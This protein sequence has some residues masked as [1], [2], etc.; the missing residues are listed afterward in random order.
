MLVE[1]SET[2]RFTSHKSHT[3]LDQLTQA[4]YNAGE[5]IKIALIDCGAKQ[6]IIRCLASRGAEV[7]VFPWNYPIAKSAQKYDG[8]FISNGPGSLL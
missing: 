7:T 3:T 1:Q 2:C 8:V 4:I 5:P 6:N